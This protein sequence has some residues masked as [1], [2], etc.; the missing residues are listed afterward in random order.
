[1]MLPFSR[2]GA[3]RDH[4]AYP[5]QALFTLPSVRLE[6]PTGSWEEGIWKSK[7]TQWPCDEF[8]PFPRVWA[9][10]RITGTGPVVPEFTAVG[11]INRRAWW[12]PEK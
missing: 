7:G 10:F 6:N 12:G 4:S 2:Q 11:Q 9:P 5:S 1:M 3:Q 8:S